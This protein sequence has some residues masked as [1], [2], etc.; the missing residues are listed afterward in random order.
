L[1]YGGKKTY[2]IS[3]TSVRRIT[4]SEAVER[5][6]S[7]SGSLTGT[8][9]GALR[10]LYD[11]VGEYMRKISALPYSFRV[12]YMDKL[13]TDAIKKAS[14]L[15]NSFRKSLRWRKSEFRGEEIGNRTDEEIVKDY[16]REY[17]EDARKAKREFNK[18]LENLARRLMPGYE[19][20][21]R[22][23][24]VTREEMVKRQTVRRFQ[25]LLEKL[26]EKGDARFRS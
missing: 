15:Y 6:I 4:A 11:K 18:N 5:F 8:L 17:V 24:S 20:P 14:S 3:G 7:K 26:D 2:I 25:D 19:S 13:M 22:D 23:S 10:N 1:K 9:E 16:E 21:L 12:N